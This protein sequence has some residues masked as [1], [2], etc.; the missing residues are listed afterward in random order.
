MNTENNLLFAEFMGFEPFHHNH[1]RCTIEMYKDDRILPTQYMEFDSNWNWILKV[2]EKIESTKATV[3]IGRMYCEI[4]YK[5][6]F[7]ENQKKE[8][9]VASGSRINAVYAACVEFINW[10]NQQK[11]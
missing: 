7:D 1:F 3:T 5:N 11:K 10:Y 8:I 6:P 9:R 4:Q 2:V